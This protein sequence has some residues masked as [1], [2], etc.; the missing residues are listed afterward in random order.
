MQEPVSTIINNDPY[1]YSSWAVAFCNV[2]SVIYQLSI[3]PLMK[4][5]I[6]TKA[7]TSIFTLVNILF[8]VVDSFTPCA[9]RPKNEITNKKAQ[10]KYE[11]LQKSTFIKNT[12]VQKGGCQTSDFTWYIIFKLSSVLGKWFLKNVYQAVL[13]KHVMNINTLPASSIM[14]PA[15]NTSG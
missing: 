1:A 10:K 13:K 7:R 6:I 8:T 3:F 9:R 15:A 12:G 14:R 2:S 4:P 11:D 5:D